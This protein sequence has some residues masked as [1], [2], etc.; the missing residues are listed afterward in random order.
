MCGAFYPNYFVRSADGG[1]IDE[2]EAVKVLGGR[3]PYRTVYFTNMDNNQ[4]GQLY[5]SSIKKFFP[6]CENI[7]VSFDQSK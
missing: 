7:S 6:D 1:Q 2:R 3:D 4:P 5:V